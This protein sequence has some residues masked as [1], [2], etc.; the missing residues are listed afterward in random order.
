[1]KVVSERLGHAN[2]TVTLSYYAHVMPGDQRQ[3]AARFAA[4]VGGAEA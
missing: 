3:A 4:I 1:M 2:V